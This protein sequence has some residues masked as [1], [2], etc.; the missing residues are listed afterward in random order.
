MAIL[1][2]HDGLAAR[3][4]AERTAMDK[5]A[6]SRALSALVERGFVLRAT[7]REDRRASRLRLSAAGRRVHDEIVPLAI[8]H[9]RRLLA[10]L[11]RE[12][13]RWLVRLLDVLAPSPEPADD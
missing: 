12:E 11:S 3:D 5:V 2:R 8:E 6:V 10:R 1:G 13:Q 4:V 9:E 7:A